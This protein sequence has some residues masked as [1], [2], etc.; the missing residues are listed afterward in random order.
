MLCLVEQESTIESHKISQLD[1]SE[2]KQSG[3]Y[4]QKDMG[5]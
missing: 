2:L 4:V 5:L 3:E 1:K